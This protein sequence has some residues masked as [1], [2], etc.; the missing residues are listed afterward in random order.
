M[1]IVTKYKHSSNHEI[2]LACDDENVEQ[3]IQEAL[4]DLGCTD[5]D[6]VNVELSG[7]C[8]AGEWGVRVFCRKTV[9]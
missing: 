3:L 6:V 5:R 7:P 1:P 4:D 8:G 2:A 9:V